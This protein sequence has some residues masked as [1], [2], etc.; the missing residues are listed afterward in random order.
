MSSKGDD[1]DFIMEED[2]LKGPENDE[3][4]RD[5]II[6]FAVFFE[7]GLAPI[8][9]VVGWLLGFPPLANFAWS[10]SDALHGAAAAL[11]LVAMFLAILSWPVG[12]LSRVKTFCEHEVIPLFDQS[13]WS[14]I[15]LISLSAGVGEEM[16]FRGV[17]QAAL[18]SWLGT[19]WGLTLASA[20][21]GL[22]HPISVAYVIIAGFLGLYL[23][24]V[25]MVNGNLLTV[26]VAHAVYDFAALGYL[27][28]AR[29][30]GSGGATLD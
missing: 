9:L 27:I 6:I 30:W 26:M 13:D 1:R 18:V 29:H 21:F 10:F 12:P 16:L 2:L 19:A 4:G 8:S 5:V 25:W 15:A 23:G 11:P 22:L 24:W 20:L 17:F 14:E 3:P 28:R 7:A